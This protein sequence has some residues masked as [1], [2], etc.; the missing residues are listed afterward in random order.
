MH[1][2]SGR[3]AVVTGG[4]KGIGAAIAKALAGAGA[5]VVVGGRDTKALD[6][7]VADI[8]EAGGNASAARCDVTNSEEVL[9]FARTVRG[10]AGPPAIVVN[11]AGVATAARFDRTD[12]AMWRKVLDVNLDGAYRVTHAF[13]GDVLAAGARGR[14]IYIASVA[15]RVGMLYTAAYTAS[16][17]GVLGLC[18]ALALELAPKG[19]TV[20]CVCPGW[21]E[22][23]MATEAVDRI[24][25]AT[26][27]SV[28]DARGELEKMS[29]QRR[30]MQPQEVAAVTLFLAS[31]AA[32]GVT[33]QGWNVDGGTVMS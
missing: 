8:R 25:R 4:G 24:V 17:H 26:G 16:K 7:V 5:Q 28:A 1:D 31:D 12:E 18:R 27:R 13:A 20:N 32:A 9:S 2:L 3:V 11:N 21:V 23:D 29:P 15:A 19:P 30:L 6:Q 10:A 22:T 33:G 14:I